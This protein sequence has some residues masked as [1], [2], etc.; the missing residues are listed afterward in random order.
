M[1]LSCMAKVS[2]NESIP[3]FN[4][5]GES[6]PYNE[7]GIGTNNNKGLIY[8]SSLVISQVSEQMLG[9]YTVQ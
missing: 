4:W 5:D 3:T 9:I 2:S 6:I 7:N 1:V 8:S